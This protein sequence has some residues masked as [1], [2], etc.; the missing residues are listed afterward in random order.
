MKFSRHQILSVLS[1]SFIALV[2]SPCQPLTGG[3]L[4]IWLWASFNSLSVFFLLYGTRTTK[5][6]KTRD[7]WSG[8]CILWSQLLIKLHG[9]WYFLTI[10]FST[11]KMFLSPW[12]LTKEDLRFLLLKVNPNL[13][14]LRWSDKKILLLSVLLLSIFGQIVWTSDVSALLGVVHCF[15]IFCYHPEISL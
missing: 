15:D 6:N 12:T 14:R 7:L 10:N 5:Q 4:P 9:F 8:K 2:S 3:K 11:I 1:F 13:V